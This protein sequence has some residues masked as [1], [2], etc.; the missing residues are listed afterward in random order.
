MS[1][2]KKACPVCGCAST[3]RLET[4]SDPVGGKDY[5]VLACAGCELVFSR[6]LLFPGGGWYEKYNYVCGYSETACAGANK[7]RFGY[8]LDR[9]PAPRRGR[10]LDV[11][12]A[13]GHFLR[14]AAQRGYQAEGL[15]VDS[16]FVA[17]ARESGLPGVSLG[18]LDAAYAGANA[19]AL[20]AVSI[21]EVLEHVDD[22][23]GFLRLAGEALKPGGT[24]LVSVPD[25][26]RPTPFGRDV[27]DYPPHHLTRWGP[28]ALKLALEKSGFEVLDMRGLPLHVWEFSRV[29]ADRSAQVILRIIKRVLFGSAAASR[30]M[31]DILKTSPSGPAACLPGKGARVRAVALY[32]AAFSAA[33]YPVFYLLLLYYRR[34]LPGVGLGLLAVA[35][36]PSLLK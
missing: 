32:H 25:N 4:Y 8:F 24:L 30:P 21:M 29:W 22:P 13:S 2:N 10:L 18:Q 16:R 27:W 20:E 6:P 12:C 36:K 1:E 31:D 26:R 28:K 5:E 35:R 33:T 23:I 14:L 34:T 19:G 7:D 9:L 3:P 11:G 17:M 15:E